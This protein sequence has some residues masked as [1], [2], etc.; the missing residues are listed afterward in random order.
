MHDAKRVAL[1]VECFRFQRVVHA[2]ER[3][4]ARLGAKRPEEIRGERAAG[5][6]DL[7]PGEIIGAVD[8]PGAGG[9]VVEPVLPG[10][11]E[12]VQPGP[13]KL[14]ADHVAERAVKRGEHPFAVA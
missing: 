1:A 2:A 13:R 10:A 8:R 6:A 7:Q 5:G 14:T 3:H 11:T 4:H 12:G 9:D